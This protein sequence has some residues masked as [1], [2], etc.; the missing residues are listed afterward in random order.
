MGKQ[1][2]CYQGQLQQS[3]NILQRTC[4]GL[5]SLR[6]EQWR[7]CWQA[8]LRKCKSSSQG[9]LQQRTPPVHCRHCAG[10]GGPRRTGRQHPYN[11]MMLTDAMAAQ[12]KAML[13]GQIAQL[14]KG[15]ANKENLFLLSFFQHVINN[16][17]K[18]L[19]PSF[20]PTVVPEFRTFAAC[21]QCCV[22]SSPTP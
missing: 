11:M 5:S 1:T 15:M 7:H 10:S 9:R 22:I 18:V 13:L 14:T 12:I 6:A 21:I 3:K 4:Q 2:Q 17:C 16:C 20:M 8:Q 19:C